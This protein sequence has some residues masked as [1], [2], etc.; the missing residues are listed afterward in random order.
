MPPDGRAPRRVVEQVA[1]DLDQALR[2]AVHDRRRVADVEHEALLLGVD[3]VPARF[4]GDAEDLVELEVAPLQAELAGA[5]ARAVEQV[6][7]QPGDQRRLAL[8]EL[9]L[10]LLGDGVD[11]RVGEQRGRHPDRRERVAQRV[12]RH[13]DEVD[14]PVVRRFGLGLQL[15]RDLRRADELAVGLEQLAQPRLVLAE[16][17]VGAAD[18]ERHRVGGEHVT[19]V[20]VAVVLVELEAARAAPLGAVHRG[21]GMAH[22]RHR[23]GAVVRVDGDADAGTERDRVGADGRRRGERIEDLAR[24]RRRVGSARDLRQQHDELVAA[25]PAD[26]VGFAHHRRQPLGR[27]AQ[28]LVADG[29]AEVVVDLLEAVEIEEQQADPGRAALRPGD[30]ALQPV[31]HQDPCRR[32]G[33]L[34]VLGRAGQLVE[35]ADGRL[36]R[37]VGLH[38]RLHQAVVHLEELRGAQAAQLLLRLLGL[39]AQARQVGTHRVGLRLEQGERAPRGGELFRFGRF[40]HGAPDHAVRRPG[41]G[42]VGL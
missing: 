39:A 7:D 12:R 5:D 37:R 34:V 40:G 13:R 11:A 1:E 16:R 22:Q 10:P 15:L 29:V 9:Q 23:V 35:A 20:G 17:G 21:I 14:L 28:H 2:I 38:R 4:R 25:V 18:R 31:E 6:V 42:R 26:R 30:R 3:R 19:G 8:H 36:R 32:A 24:D 41:L 33:E 27:Q